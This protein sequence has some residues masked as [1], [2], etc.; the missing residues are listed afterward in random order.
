MGLGLPVR[1]TAREGCPRRHPTSRTVVAVQV[2]PG[3][4]QNKNYSS[5]YGDTSKSFY[6]LTYNSHNVCVLTYGPEHLTPLSGSWM[7]LDLFLSFSTLPP[8]HPALESGTS[9]TTHSPPLYESSCFR[10]DRPP[11]QCRSPR[12]SSSPV[13]DICDSWS[14]PRDVSP[15]HR[16]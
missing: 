2:D 16:S 15:S 10:S 6:F 9:S 5:T 8:P 11:L 3:E 13:V 4:S 7:F 14:F 1:N 12:G